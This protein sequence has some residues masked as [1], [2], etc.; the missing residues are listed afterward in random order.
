MKYEYK[1]SQTHGYYL[2]DYV[3]SKCLYKF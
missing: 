1:L 2:L 3:Y